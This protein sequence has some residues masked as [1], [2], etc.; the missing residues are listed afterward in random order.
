VAHRAR[1]RL[2]AP[3]CGERQSV[4]ESRALTDE[5]LTRPRPSLDPHEP[6][7]DVRPAGAGPPQPSAQIDQQAVA[8]DAQHAALDLSA[9]SA[10]PPSVHAQ[11]GVATDTA[12]QQGVEGRGEV[13]PRALQ[14]GLTVRAAA[15]DERAEP[16]QVGGAAR[17]GSQLV[18]LRRGVDPRARRPVEPVRAERDRP[19]GTAG[20]DVD[21]HAARGD[22]L[23]RFPEPG[24]ADALD[25][26]SKSPSI[27]STTRWA[28]RRRSVADAAAAS[29]T[30]LP[31][32]SSQSPVV[33]WHARSRVRDRGAAASDQRRL[34]R[35]AHDA[36]GATDSGQS[37]DPIAG[38]STSGHRGTKIP[39]T[40][41]AYAGAITIT[42]GRVRRPPVRPD[43]SPQS[44][45]VRTAAHMTAS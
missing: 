41:R 16:G 4:A 9:P 32:S 15:G 28:P 3:R 11:D 43:S 36:A 18:K 17:A 8:V 35:R 25:D 20:P 22:V 42:R 39:D 37:V 19:V 1:S 31:R 34:T 6:R 26:H 5:M 24:A 33:R 12:V 10:V 38:M 44:D 23:D 30:S 7:P 27:R 21:H 40:I 29:R 2:G 45:P 14:L 13:P